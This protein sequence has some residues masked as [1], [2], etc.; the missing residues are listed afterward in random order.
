MIMYSSD[1]MSLVSWEA[2]AN[3]RIPLASGGH[4]EAEG[5]EGGKIRI[6]SVSSTDPMDYLDLRYQP[7]NI[8]NLDPTGATLE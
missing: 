5:L 3:Y 8:L 2:H 4:V 6:L 1:P 7:G